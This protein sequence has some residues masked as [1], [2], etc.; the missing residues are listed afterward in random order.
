MLGLTLK[1]NFRAEKP[2]LLPNYICQCEFQHVRGC[3]I[4]CCCSLGVTQPIEH[5][6]LD[7]KKQVVARSSHITEVPHQSTPRTKARFSDILI[8][9]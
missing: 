8:F 5:L 2:N 9:K 1:S 3:S 7:T 6:L 4:M